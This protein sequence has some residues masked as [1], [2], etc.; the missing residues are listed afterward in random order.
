MNV[1]DAFTTMTREIK[2]KVATSQPDLAEIT[3]RGLIGA[4]LTP[5][6]RLA[7]KEKWFC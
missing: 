4:L 6:N 1:E 5:Q 2:G 7:L 3:T